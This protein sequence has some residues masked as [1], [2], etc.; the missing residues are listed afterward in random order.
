[1]FGARPVRFRAGKERLQH[2][3]CALFK[4]ENAQV[5][6]AILPPAGLFY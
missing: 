5:G 3:F 2:A 1:M 6:F 4:P